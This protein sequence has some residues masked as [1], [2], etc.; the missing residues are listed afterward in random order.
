MSAPALPPGRTSTPEE[1]AVRVRTSVAEVSLVETGE[2]PGTIRSYVRTGFDVDA[3]EEVALPPAVVGAL[4]ALY[5]GEVVRRWN[6][7]A[8][9]V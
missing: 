2:R 4:L 6:T 3:L 9:A 8:W 5:P 1:R 7:P